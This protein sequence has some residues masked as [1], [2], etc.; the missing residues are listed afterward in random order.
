[1]PL[2]VYECGACKEAFETRHSIK[3]NLEKCILCLEPDSLKRIPAIPIIIKKEKGKPRIECGE[4]ILAPRQK[5]DTQ[6]SCNFV[7]WS[8]VRRM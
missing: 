7:S 4:Y 8:K 1:M 6:R 2:Y 3:E 5:S